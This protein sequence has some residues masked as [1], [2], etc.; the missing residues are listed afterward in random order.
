VEGA[1]LAGGVYVLKLGSDADTD[2]GFHAQAGYF[3]VPKKLEIGGRFG[4]VPAGDE[5]THEVLGTVNV[6][7][8]GH[9]LKWQTSGGA[10]HTTGDAGGSTFVVLTQA[11]LIF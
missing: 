6:F 7:A 8:H 9:S 2:V 1:S 3:L 4:Q 11:Q 5:R 10:L